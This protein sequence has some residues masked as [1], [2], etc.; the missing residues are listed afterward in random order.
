MAA[1]EIRFHTDAR[2]RMQLAVIAAAP[3][4]SGNHFT[5]HRFF[6][7][8]IGNDDAAHR[9]F[10]LLDAA[11]QHTILQRSKIHGTPPSETK[12]SN[13]FGTLCSRVPAT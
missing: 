4:P 12:G 11:D 3:G 1:K 10:F 5:L 9:L 13:T 6:L 7:G 8:G 2:E